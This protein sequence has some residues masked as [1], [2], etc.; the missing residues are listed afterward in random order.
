MTSDLYQGLQQTHFSLE[1]IPDI[2]ENLEAEELLDILVQNNRK[3]EVIDGVAK[4]ITHAVV[5]DFV[6]FVFESLDA[7]RHARFSVAYALLRKPFVDELFILEQILVDKADFVDRY[8]FQGDTKLYDPSNSSLFDSV[9][10]PTIE[11]SIN[12]LPFPTDFNADTVYEFR[13]DKAVKYGMNWVS[14][15]ALH[16]VTNHSKYRTL[17]K[18]LNFVFANSDDHKQLWAHYYSVVSYL[19]HYSVAVIDEIVFSFLPDK[20][21]RKHIKATRRAMIQAYSNALLPGN[22]GRILEL[23]AIL[24]SELAHVC[25]TC[26]HNIV[27]TPNELTTFMLNDKLTCVK[28]KADQFADIEFQDRFLALG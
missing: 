13:Y 15:Q 3:D 20:I 4:R 7:I 2:S 17:N 27:F 22:E 23:F 19:L 26:G 25:K 16:I 8:Y 5:D 6:Q 1:G 12:K 21:H 11:A 24:S 18:Q 14:N 9:R 28:C 10:K